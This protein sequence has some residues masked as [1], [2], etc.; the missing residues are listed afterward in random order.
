MDFFLKCKKMKF[1]NSLYKEGNIKKHKNI[2]F[3]IAKSFQTV[4]FIQ[5][6]DTSNFKFNDINTIT[7]S[8]NLN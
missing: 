1:S 8:F 7:K 5:P 4:T 2:L 6:S 3:L